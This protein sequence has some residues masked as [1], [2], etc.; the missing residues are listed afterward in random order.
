MRTLSW[1]RYFV[2]LIIALSLLIGLWRTRHKEELQVARP[3]NLP[4]LPRLMRPAATPD[5]HPPD[6]NAEANEPPPVIDEV[7]VEKQEVCEGEENLVTVKAH[8]E[9]GTDA[10][11]HYMVGLELGPS[12]PLRLDRSA[13]ATQNTWPTIQVFGRNS[14]SRVLVPPYRI[15]DCKAERRL[16]VVAHLRPNRWGEYDLQAKIVASAA[17]KPFHPVSF[18]WSFGDGASDSTTLPLV[19]HDYEQRS[20]DNLYSYE[21]IV[22]EA[23]GDD[24]ETLVGR[25]SLAL[26]N[27]AY[28]ALQDRG[29]VQLFYSLEP[30]YPQLSEDGTVHQG[31]RLWQSRKGHPVTLSNVTRVRHLLDGQSLSPEPVDPGTLTSSRIIPDAPG[32]DA[33]IALD[34]RNDQETY[35]VDYLIEGQSDDGIPARGQFSVMRPLMPPTRER[36][37]KITDPGLQARIVRARELLQ[38]PLVSEED[39]LRLEMEGRFADLPPRSPDSLPF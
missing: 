37:S 15:K 4:A 26:A 23:T 24:G 36:H 31:V 11:L 2:V 20:Q 12:V 16:L 27:P 5:E 25:T 9:N 28:R 19:T 17:G 21:L 18:R 33:A 3:L 22:V 7:T 29:V 8:T 10:D 30:R 14:M 38:R 6:R 1:R 34:L 35:S 13:D 32:I 39:L